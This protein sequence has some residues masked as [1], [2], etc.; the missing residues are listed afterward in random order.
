[1]SRISG[2]RTK[3]ARTSA[4]RGEDLKNVDSDSSDLSTQT[5]Q[6][7]SKRL[8]PRSLNLQMAIYIRG[9]ILEIVKGKRSCIHFNKLKTESFY[10][11]A[12]RLWI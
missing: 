6:I 1:M 3:R 5:G 10:V 4:D 7:V 9:R 2:V 11:R 8:G 12:G